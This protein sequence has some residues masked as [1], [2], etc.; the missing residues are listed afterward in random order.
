[1]ALNDFSPWLTA[2]PD[3]NKE[4]TVFL[5]PHAGGGASAFKPP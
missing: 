2:K 3:P 4:M 5:L 1:M